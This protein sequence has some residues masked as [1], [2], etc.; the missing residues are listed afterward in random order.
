LSSKKNKRRNTQAVEVFASSNDFDDSP[1]YKTCELLNKPNK[2]I[3][4]EMCANITSISYKPLMPITNVAKRRKQSNK[5]DQQ[6]SET[7][8]S[9]EFAMALAKEI[10]H[11]QDKINSFAMEIIPHALALLFSNRSLLVIYCLFV[12]SNV[13]K[14]PL[15]KY[16]NSNEHDFNQHVSKARQFV[17]SELPSLLEK[18]GLRL[19]FDASMNVNKYGFGV[20]EPIFN[21]HDK[22]LNMAEIS[23][24]MQLVDWHESLMNDQE[25]KNAR[26][27]ACLTLLHEFIHVLSFIKFGKVEG[28]SISTPKVEKFVIKTL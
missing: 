9:E 20:S 23:L 7:S 27:F 16:L 1:T 10:I 18:N 21:N 3:V 25:K 13:D 26:N 5:T 11:N 15:T 17:I 6:T 14:V 28:S 8:S 4:E 22:K 24:S 2:Q 19:V 12:D